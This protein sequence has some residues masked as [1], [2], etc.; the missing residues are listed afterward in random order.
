MPQVWMANGIFDIRAKNCPEAG[1][2]TNTIKSESL[3]QKPSES[4]R[5]SPEESIEITKLDAAKR[6]LRTAIQLWFNDG[7]SVATHTLLAAALEVIHTLFK[8]KGL[9]GLFFDH[10]RI[11]EERRGEFAKLAKAPATFFKHAQRDPDA[12]LAF[13][14][15]INLPLMVF[16]AVGLSRM[17]EKPSLETSALA[18]W[19]RLHEPEF[20]FPEFR[21]ENVHPDTPLEE[22]RRLT[23]REFYECFRNC[24]ARGLLPGSR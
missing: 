24:W 3:S 7:D 11:R 9:S 6:H 1:G 22:L 8:R 19:I 12:K 21:L 18:E 17:G 23:K 4:M 16:C 14:P 10:P 20:V 15:G 5:E 13:N 2:A